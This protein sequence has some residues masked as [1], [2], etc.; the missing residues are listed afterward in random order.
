MKPFSISKNDELS[1]IIQ[2]TYRLTLD[3]WSHPGK[4]ISLAEQVN[5]INFISDF[6]PF[7]LLIGLM[8]LDAEASFYISSS[9]N[10]SFSK[11]INQITYAR[12]VQINEADFIF[13]LNDASQ[14]QIQ[15]A[16]RKA[17]SGTFLNPHQSATMMMEVASLKIKGGMTLSGPGIDKTCSFGVDGAEVWI[18]LRKEKNQEFPLGIDMMIFD[19]SNQLVCLPRTTQIELVQERKSWDM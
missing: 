15:E 5:A 4:I 13:I 10:P 18:P 16:F 9:D 14:D 12:Q 7:A 2:K 8:L 17:K 11:L 19:H 3:G 1:H 6:H